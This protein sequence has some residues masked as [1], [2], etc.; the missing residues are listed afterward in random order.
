MGWLTIYGRVAQWFKALF[1]NLKVV[2]LQVENMIKKVCHLR[3]PQFMLCSITLS[4]SPSYS[5]FHLTNFIYLYISP[6]HYVALTISVHLLT[7]IP[8]WVRK[9]CYDKAYVFCKYSNSQCTWFV[10]L[11]RK[12]TFV[13]IKCTTHNILKDDF[14]P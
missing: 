7:K 14:I 6:A 3:Y 4:L 2:S 10:S 13:E 5:V 11:Y 1:W 12:R 9:I 8:G